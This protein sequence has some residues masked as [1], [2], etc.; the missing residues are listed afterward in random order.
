M[1]DVQKYFS[2][3]KWTPAQIES[4]AK[5]VLEDKKKVYEKIASLPQ[6]KQ[7]FESVI[8]AIE[9]IET[10]CNDVL[11]PIGVLKNVSPDKKT[12]EMAKK[13]IE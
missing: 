9:S 2:F 12:R 10:K 4:K 8:L 7:N 11:R 3:V 5:K 6:S 13:M 1:K